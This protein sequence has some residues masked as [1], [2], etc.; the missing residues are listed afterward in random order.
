MKNYYDLSAKDTLDDLKSSESGLTHEEAQK[1]LQEYGENKL[2]EKKNSSFIVKFLKQFANVMIIILLV[3]AV[4]SLVIALNSDH[5]AK[6]LIEP[7]VIFGIVVLNAL[8]GAFQE[9]KAENALAA[10]KKMSEPYA[11]VIRDGKEEKVRTTELVIGDIVVLEAGD[12]VPADLRLITSAN[13]ECLEASLTGE[14]LP[15]KK[16]E[17]LQLPE[18]TPLGDRKNMCYSS[19]EI[20]KGRGV[21]VVTATGTQTEIGKIASMLAEA[22]EGKSPLEQN[23]DKLG[24]VLTIAVLIISVIIFFINKFI[25]NQAAIDSFMTAVT[26]AVAAIPESLP[27]VV[28]II[29]SLGVTKLSKKN[30]IIRKLH[31]VETLGCCNYICSDKTGTITQN[32]MTVKK[33]YVNGEIHDSEKINTSDATTLDLINCMALC[34]DA[35]MQDGKLIGDPTETALIAL[36]E[37]CKIDTH[38]LAQD[39]KRVNEL[40]FDSDRKLMSTLNVQDNRIV[41]W[42]KGAT[43]QLLERCTKIV[44]NGVVSDITENDKNDIMSANAE[45]CSKAL[46]VLGLAMVTF[47]SEPAE[48]EE[49]NLTFIGLVGMIDPPRPEVFEALKKCNK[50]GMKAVMITGD[51]RE[52]AYAIASELKMVS[53]KDEVVDGAYIDNF[54]DEELVTEIKKFSVFTRVSPEHKVRIVKALKAS[55]NIVAMTG[56]GVNDSPSIKS[57]DVGIGMGI[58][59]TEVTK[60][61]ADLILTDDNFATII[62]AVE[63]GRKI[64]SNI[65]KTIQFLL[66]CNIA[67]ILTIFLLTLIFPKN[68]IFAP[69]QILFVNLV[70]D[71]L[72]AI[73]LGVEPAEKNLMDEKPRKDEHSLFT[74]DYFGQIIYN[75]FWQFVLVS[76]AYIIGNVCYESAEIASTMAFLALSLIQLVHMFNS[77]LTTTIFCKHKV[78]KMVYLSLGICLVMLFAVALIPPFMTAF[79]VVSLSFTQW[80]IVVGLSLCI[81]PAVEIYKAITSIIKKKKEVK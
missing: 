31:I 48:L 81:I 39:F 19:C 52:T 24:K 34:N 15:S 55:G 44:K 12:V 32:K 25:A 67:E 7:I 17:N 46:R 28:T 76:L 40:P 1:R 35:R 30:V 2:P 64:Y 22:T 26:L 59:G 68:I 29:L 36:A 21:G 56:D 62:V 65:K 54:T 10:L 13:L 53:S 20:A 47:D 57:A 78:N 45:L 61:A 41:M 38:K 75:G 77:K 70:T 73:A 66:S 63:E 11:K 16:D 23:L 79:E 8:L 3:S 74:K 69:L 4:I 27:A 14:S 6:E 58:T 49:Q 9:A 5:V 80:L 43:D 51:H 42:T 18:K 33:V 72:P 60:G 71:T 37:L 50:A